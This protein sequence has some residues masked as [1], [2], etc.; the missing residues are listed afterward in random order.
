MLGKLTI[1]GIRVT[2]EGAVYVER[3]AVDLQL[4]SLPQED[5]SES[6][7]GD[8]LE[9]VAAAAALE[10]VA[11]PFLEAPGARRRLVS[12]VDPVQDGW[13]ADSE[14]SD[15]EDYEELGTEEEE[16]S[17]WPE[18]NGGGESSGRHDGWLRRQRRL[19]QRRR[20]VDDRYTAEVLAWPYRTIGQLMYRTSSSI[21][22]C[23][24]NAERVCRSEIGN[25]GCWKALQC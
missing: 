19:Q 12:G 16:G 4:S 25:E 3:R 5:S 10:A 8:D 2:S 21:H 24:G 14:A 22:I 1:R 9:V 13:T 15:E 17:G 7:V 23:S 6:R 18:G 20:L 11:G